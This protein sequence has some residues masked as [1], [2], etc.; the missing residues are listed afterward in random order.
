MRIGELDA[1]LERDMRRVITPE[2]GEVIVSYYEEFSKA[3]RL[4]D[5]LDWINTSFGKEIKQGQMQKYYFAH[6]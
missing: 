4:G 6:R 1:M 2:V 3:R 5:L